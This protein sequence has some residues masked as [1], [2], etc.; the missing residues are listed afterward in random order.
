MSFYSF[1]LYLLSVCAFSDCLRC[2]THTYSFWIE[3]QISFLLFL[4]ENIMWRVNALIIGHYYFI[5]NT[6]VE[7]VNVERV[8]RIRALPSKWMSCHGN[9]I[10]THILRNFSY[11]LWYSHT[12]KETPGSFFLVCVSFKNETFFIKAKPP[13]HKPRHMCVA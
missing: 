7:W 1:C 5:L 13:K 12:K 4:I 10:R 2:D 8:C 11:F 6:F 9:L 3:N